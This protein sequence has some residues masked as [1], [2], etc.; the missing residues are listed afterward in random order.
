MERIKQFGAGLRALGMEPQPDPANCKDFNNATGNNIFL[1]Y[2]NTCADWVTAAQVKKMQ[3]NLL[4][5][6]QP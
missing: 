1:I 2:E 5:P 6:F 4:A 3:K